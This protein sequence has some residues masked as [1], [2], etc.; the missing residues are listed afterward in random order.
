MIQCSVLPGA[1]E[2]D[3]DRDKDRARDEDRERE[4][5]RETKT[6]RLYQMS[7]FYHLKEFFL[8]T[9]GFKI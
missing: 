2:R 6:E 7:D 3:E 1:N 8:P 5:E 4:R 9:I